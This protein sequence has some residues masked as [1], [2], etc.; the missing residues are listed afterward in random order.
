MRGNQGTAIFFKDDFS[1]GKSDD[2][3]EIFVSLILNEKEL[4]ELINLFII[5]YSKNIED[6]RLE[7]FKKE[8][9]NK[10]EIFLKSNRKEKK[11]PYFKIGSLFFDISNRASIDPNSFHL[12]SY[13]RIEWK[14][15]IHSSFTGKR[16]FSE[17]I[18]VLGKNKVIEF[19]NKNISDFIIN[20]FSKKIEN[21]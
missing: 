9:G 17:K 6:K 3:I 4:G 7:N 8:I 11:L 20:M 19:K 1:W 5:S 12:G 14:N 2:Q 10:I 15:L 16:D 13:E 18:K 21:V